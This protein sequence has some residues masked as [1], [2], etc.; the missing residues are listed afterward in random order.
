[1]LSSA[2]GKMLLPGMQVK[3]VEKQKM[4]AIVIRQVTYTKHMY[5]VIQGLSQDTVNKHQLKE[6]CLMRIGV[7]SLSVKKNAAGRTLFKESHEYVQSILLLIPG[8]LQSNKY[9]CFGGKVPAFWTILIDRQ[10]SHCTPF[11][12]ACNT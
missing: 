9:L 11:L 10:P 8:G 4:H 6:L 5:H 7:K 12:Q 2:D 1:M 3:V